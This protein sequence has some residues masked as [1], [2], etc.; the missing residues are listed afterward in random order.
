[1]AEWHHQLNG[2]EFEQAPRDGEGQGSWR[3]TVD[4]V[5]ESVKTER[6][7]SILGKHISETITTINTINIYHLQKFLPTLFNFC[8]GV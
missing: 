5:T 1:M 2:Y 6:L 8:V 7:N 4:G 3:A